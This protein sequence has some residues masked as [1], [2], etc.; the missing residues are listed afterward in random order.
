MKE[1]DKRKNHISRK[2]HMMYISFN[3]VRHPVIKTALNEYRKASWYMQNHKA[4]PQTG[5]QLAALGV[6][7]GRHLFR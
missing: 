4:Q 1:C 2:L 3:K 5:L 6:L 7:F